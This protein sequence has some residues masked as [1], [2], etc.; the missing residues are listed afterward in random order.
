M[1]NSY[2][3][4]G[5]NDYEYLSKTKGSGFN[6]I[7][8]FHCQQICEKLLKSI[9]VVKIPDAESR[10]KT[11]NLDRLY[12][13]ISDEI[14]IDELTELYLSKLTDF[15]FDAR[16]PGNDFIN[17]SDK[18]LSRSLEVVEVVHRVVNEWHKSRGSSDVSAMIDAIKLGAGIINK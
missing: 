8:A 16:Y 13:L 12:G 4:I 7:E 2:L 9:V 5:N 15:Y 18:D 3:S 6:N 17:V 10:I 14:E 1:D 11:H